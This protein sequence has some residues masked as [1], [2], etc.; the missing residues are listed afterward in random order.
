MVLDAH[1]S[2]RRIVTLTDT[3][4]SPLAAY[5]GVGLLLGTD[6]ASQLQP[7]SGA[8]ALVQTLVSAIIRP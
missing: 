2:D 8:V 1:V 3:A 4:E 7:I 6:T 5:A